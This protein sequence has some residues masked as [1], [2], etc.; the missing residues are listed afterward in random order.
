[1]ATT[2]QV[3]V[4]VCV[5]C[6]IYNAVSYWLWWREKR[7]NNTLSLQNGLRTYEWEGGCVDKHS[8][9]HQRVTLT[10]REILYDVSQRGSSQYEDGD[11]G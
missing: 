1:M 2:R 11:G 7:I 5:I 9:K 6:V 8:N 10:E 4:C 3:F